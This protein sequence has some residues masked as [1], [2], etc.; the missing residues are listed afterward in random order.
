MKKYDR[1]RGIEL[2]KEVYAGDAQLPPGGADPFIDYMLETLF[3]TLWADE[4]LSIRERRLLLIGAIT[5]LGDAT[6]L[7]I[8]LR[9]AFKRGELT[10]AQLDA[11]VPFLTQYVGYPRGSLLFGIASKLKAGAGP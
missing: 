5:A 4:T 10:P 9:A 2:F 11:L 1:E 7:E 3:G 8:Q 6:T